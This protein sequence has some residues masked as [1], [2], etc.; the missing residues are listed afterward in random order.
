APYRERPQ[1]HPVL[2]PLP[3]AE[4]QW[5]DRRTGIDPDGLWPGRGR[6]GTE[7][8]DGHQQNAGTERRASRIYRLHLSPHPVVS[9]C[10]GR[11][12]AL[13]IRRVTFQI[14]TSVGQGRN[15]EA[16]WRMSYRR[17]TSKPSV[18]RE[19]GAVAASSSTFAAHPS[20]VRRA[21]PFR[22]A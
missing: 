10:G 9:G 18:R 21:E 17:W 19:C 6:T 20:V 2:G 13:R 22:S 7:T 3:V 1:L 15:R 14:S 5:G 12:G 16:R 4:R 8:E 11:E